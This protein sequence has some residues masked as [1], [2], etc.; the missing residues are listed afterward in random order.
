MRFLKAMFP[1]GLRFEPDPAEAVRH[2]TEAANCGHAEANALMALLCIEGR[3]CDK[4]FAAAKRFATA[5]AA[6][7]VAEGDFRTRRHLLP[8]ARRRTRFRRRR[9]LV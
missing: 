3:G 5:A 1:R 2:L 9:R 6:A 4:D 7:G 8:R